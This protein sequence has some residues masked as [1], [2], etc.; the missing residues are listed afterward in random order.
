LEFREAGAVP[1]SIPLQ[2]EQLDQLALALAQRLAPPKPV[3]QPFG[4]LAAAWLQRIKLRRVDPENERR[5]LA[6]LGP[7]WGLTELPP[8][9]AFE[10]R[11]T[12]DGC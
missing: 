5:H 10:A 6:H 7:L 2:P 8:G 4:E 9:R 3:E 1:Y 12:L 11:K